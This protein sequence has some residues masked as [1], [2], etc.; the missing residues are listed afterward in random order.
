MARANLMKTS[1]PKRAK[2]YPLL[3]AH[4]KDGAFVKGGLRDQFHYRHFG[5]EAA[6]GR[7]YAAHV[8]KAAPGGKPP[9]PHHVHPDCEFLLVRAP[10]LGAVLVRGPR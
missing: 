2:K 10:R 9:I 1:A 4:A 8:I 3:I 6:T 5:V 7:K